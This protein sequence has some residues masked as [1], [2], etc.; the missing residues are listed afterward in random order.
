MDVH[1]VEGSIA[2]RDVCLKAVEGQEAIYHLGAIMGARDNYLGFDVNLAATFYLLEAA[3]KKCPNLHR[4]VFASSD[5][6]IPHG[7]EIPDVIPWQTTVEPVGMYTLSKRIGEILCYSYF[8]SNKIPT[9]CVRFPY[10]IGIGEVL[11]LPIKKWFL[12]STYRGRFNIQDPTPEQKEAID[13]FR[14]LD[15]GDDEQL[16]LPRCMNGL[17]YKKHTG[18]V[19]DIVQGLLLALEKDEA[20]GLAFPL[21]GVPFRW[22]LGVPYMAE[23]L[24]RDYIDVKVPGT[25]TYYEYDVSKAHEVLGYN[26][27]HDEK[28]SIDIALALLRG[29]DTGWFPI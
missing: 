7:G 4:F 20:V 5:V 22:D 23:K 19:R 8:R 27:I 13:K 10:M 18:D 12:A 6:C 14:S 21:P 17:G 29:E 3:A 9:V 15:K 25:G 11:Q 16:M 1:V 2:D 26:P 28:S 24:G